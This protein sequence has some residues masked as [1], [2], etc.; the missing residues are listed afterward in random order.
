MQ[1]VAEIA[2]PTLAPWNPALAAHAGIP[3]Q[4]ADTYAQTRS[5]LGDNNNPS[6]TTSGKLPPTWL[7]S[8]IAV[9]PQKAQPGAQAMLWDA[10]G[11]LCA[12]ESYV[13]GIAV[14]APSSP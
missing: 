9:P 1:H 3:G 12:A 4:S 11:L 5:T 7:L 14:S 10:R 13:T 8:A 6:T 2:E